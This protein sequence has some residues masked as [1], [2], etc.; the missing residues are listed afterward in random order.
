MKTDLLTPCDRCPFR[1]DIPQFLRPGR[2]IEL[3]REMIEH[4]A[5]FQ[6]HK[7]VDY[8]KADDEGA[9]D[10]AVAARSPKAQ[11]CAGAMILLEKLGLPNQLMR[12]MERIRQYDRRRLNM[13]A[14][15]YDSFHE[16]EQAARVLTPRRRLRTARR[17]W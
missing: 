17:K 11:H 1:S 5:S 9:V 13:K 12:W 8:S 16:M 2:V 10:S 14:P 3:R 15:V 4:Q 7:T 6:C